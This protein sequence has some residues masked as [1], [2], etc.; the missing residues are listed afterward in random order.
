MSSNKFYTELIS[1]VEAKGGQTSETCSS[2]T[3]KVQIK[4]SRDHLFNE[5]VLGLR[6][7]K[8]CEECRDTSSSKSLQEKLD[9]VGF[10]YQVFPPGE[11]TLDQQKYLSLLLS[12]S[13]INETRCLVGVDRLT[14][15]EKGV[16]E[17][18]EER[19]T[20]IRE[21]VKQAKKQGYFMLR[22]LETT[23]ENDPELPKWL[24]EQLSDPK[25]FMT[26]TPVA[27]EWLSSEIASP[28]KVETKPEPPIKLK[29]E[30]K[31]VPVP[32][33]PV[34]QENV[35]KR[36]TYPVTR[37]KPQSH[38]KDV[39]E[40]PR[41]GKMILGYCRV[42]TVDQS[43]NGVSLVTQED[44]IMRYSKSINVPVKRMYFDEGISGTKMDNRDALQA[45]LSDLRPGC[46]VVVYSLSRFARNS[47]QASEMNDTI[48]KK[49]GTLKALDCDVDMSS[50][51]GN[52]MFQLQNGF[53]EYESK[54][55]GERVSAAMS[56]LSIN[57]KLKT[58]P[59]FGWK[60]VGKGT[61][62][63]KDEEEYA[64]V[65][66]IKNMSTELRMCPTQIAKVLTKDGACRRKA[67]AWYCSSVIKILDREKALA[68]KINEQGSKEEP[69]T[70]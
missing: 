47:I 34:S 7:G 29:V 36:H 56:F 40:C 20:L 57:G 46:V 21:E 63:V 50:A 22:L 25:P 49:G 68:L 5:N 35:P 62:F 11:T 41:V 70:E 2:I 58:K 44:A 42:S 23:V 61:P 59:P 33:P 52:L 55:T 51:S 32:S 6:K 65:E 4:C 45:L 17:F 39:D 12:I 69:S 1:L 67:K 14:L 37:E 26:M 43:V 54:L 64:V 16:G 53:A 13:D 30:A 24:E 28:P 18:Q 19:R 8:W 48:K 3:K 9:S 31:P 60:S 66:R 10:E 38:W 27:Y 15:D